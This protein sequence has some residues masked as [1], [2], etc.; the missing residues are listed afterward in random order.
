MR[1]PAELLLPFHPNYGQ[2]YCLNIIYKLNYVVYFHKNALLTPHLHDF[3][4]Y[5][6]FIAKF[7]RNNLRTFS[8]NLFIFYLF[9]AEKQLPPTY[10]L[11]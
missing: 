11:F 6:S 5:R 4:N 10:S 2:L 1:C 3:D 9:G 7:C 8:A